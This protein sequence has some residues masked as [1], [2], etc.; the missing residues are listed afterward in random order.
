MNW[1]TG[2]TLFAL[3]NAPAGCTLSRREVML[4][5]TTDVDCAVL[6]RFEVRLLRGTSADVVW[7]RT[8]LRN[9]C[10]AVGASIPRAPLARG[11]GVDP[12]VPYRLG[13]VDSRRTD[14]RVRIEV[15]GRRPDALVLQTV[16]ET[17][18]VDGQ[19][20]AVPMELSAVCLSPI[21][22]PANFAC[23]RD[24]SG[25]A[26][27]GSVFRT[28]GTLGTFVASSSLVA[29]DTAVLEDEP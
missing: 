2:A 5:L 7:S 10:P 23:R 25:A 3:L 1:W 15:S 27:C 19:V 11:N 22:C 6:D 28:P 21:T 24:P 17:D 9:D 29:D 12:G 4:V 20:Y 14:E 16:A 18:F 8:Y 13:I 26:G